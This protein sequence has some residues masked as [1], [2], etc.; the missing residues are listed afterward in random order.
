[1]VHGTHTGSKENVP[2]A[3]AL[4]MGSLGVGTVPRLEV[5]NGQ[6]TKA[7]NK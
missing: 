2:S 7:G 3:R 1:M 5:V 6:T 4:E